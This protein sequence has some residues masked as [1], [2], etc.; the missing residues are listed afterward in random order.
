MTVWLGDKRRPKKEERLQCP[1]CKTYHKVFE[2]IV[3]KRFMYG[4]SKCSIKFDRNGI[5]EE[6]K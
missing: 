5:I 1:R 6:R 4:C 3:K 2:N